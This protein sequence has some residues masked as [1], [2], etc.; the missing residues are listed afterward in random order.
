MKLHV[1]ILGCKLEVSQV[2]SKINFWDVYSS[3][4]GDPNGYH[5]LTDTFTW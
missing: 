5:R 4:L 1:K 2:Y 3:L